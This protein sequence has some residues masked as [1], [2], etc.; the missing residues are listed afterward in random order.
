MPVCGFLVLL[1]VASPVAVPVLL[2]PG[3]S[4]PAALRVEWLDH[5]GRVVREEERRLLDKR[6]QLDAPPSA[7]SFQVV[8]GGFSSRVSTPAAAVKR[9]GIVL[10]ATGH[11]RIGGLPDV[12]TVSLFFRDLGSEETPDL[13]EKK[14]KRDRGS[15]EPRLSLEWPAGHYALGCDAGSAFVPAIFAEIEVRPGET[16]D[17]ALPDL[18]GRRLSVVA[19][20][21]VTKKP[22][23]G[24]RL[25]A[26]DDATAAD[27]LFVTL[28]SRRAGETGPD[29]LLQLGAL[30]SRSVALTIGAERKRSAELRLPERSGPGTREVFL[31]PFQRLEVSLTGLDLKRE[32]KGLV[33]VAGTCRMRERWM[34]CTPADVRRQLLDEDGRAVFLDMPPGFA[35]VSLEQNGRLTASKWSRSL[36]IP[37]TRTSRHSSCLCGHCGSGRHPTP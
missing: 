8:G 23:R 35:R 22:L 33:L 24:A 5:E 25:L 19:R 13:K 28:L 10:Q 14:L 27:R 4:P 6:L 3:S 16:L 26:A 29:G 15:A 36:R 37:K 30:A 2:P 11:L 17:L 21:R 31:A 18:S 7:E 1:A 9:G 32:G 34:P 12:D 20:D